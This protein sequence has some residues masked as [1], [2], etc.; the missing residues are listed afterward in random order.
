MD[1][2]VDPDETDPRT[3]RGSGPHDDLRR[4]EEIGTVLQRAARTPLPYQYEEDRYYAEDVAE[5]F[6][7]RQFT[8]A[9]VVYNCGVDTERR[10]KMLTRGLFWG[11]GEDH[12]RFKAQYRRSPPP[13]DSIPFEEYTVWTRY[14]YGHIERTDDGLTFTSG[15]RAPEERLETLA[16]ADLYEPVRQRLVELELV[17]NPPFAR[18]RLQELDEWDDYRTQFR[19]D[20]DAF[21]MGP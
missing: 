4:G 15:E 18:Y 14:Q 9:R 1:R 3:W 13:T 20:D 17:R 6:R 16:W 21:A 2:W 11:G 7:S 10:I 8:N 5:T 19:Y 12:Q